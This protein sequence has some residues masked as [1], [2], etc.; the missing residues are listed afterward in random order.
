[1]RPLT[2]YE[3]EKIEL[4]LQMGKNK[5]WIASKLNRDYS[6]IKREIK[7]NSGEH[8]PYKASDAQH[9]AQRRA[10]STNKRKLDKIKNKKLPFLEVLCR[11][12]KLLEGKQDF[13]ACFDLCSLFSLHLC[14]RSAWLNSWHIRKP[15][16]LLTAPFIFSDK[17]T[18]Q[19]RMAD[20]L[21]NT[22]L[23]RKLK[24]PILTIP[25]KL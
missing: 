17:S 13:V 10:K 19:R 16:L 1:M 7:R 24:M 9:F 15:I 21:H 14:S 22:V 3:R 25:K 2:L 20:L 4:Y 18:A 11:N 6:V 8:L 23:A 5:T 12:S